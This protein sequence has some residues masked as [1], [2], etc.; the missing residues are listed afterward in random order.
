MKNLILILTFLLSISSFSQEIN[1]IKGKYYVNGKQISSRETRQ[2]LA[3]NLEALSLFK[4]AKSKESTGGLLIAVGGAAVTVDLV[5]GLVSDVKYPSVATYAGAVAILTAIPVLSG[6]H[7]KIKEAIDLYN[8]D[9]VKK[10]GVND[11]DLELNIIANHYGYGI[12]IQF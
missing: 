6:K 9:A 5:I 12:Q 3:S 4:E 1:L 8:K 2:L 7:K 11:S 10:L